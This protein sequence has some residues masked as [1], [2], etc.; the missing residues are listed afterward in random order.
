MMDVETVRGLLEVA[1]MEFML[2][3][4]ILPVILYFLSSLHLPR[5]EC[6]ISRYILESVADSSRRFL[7]SKLSLGS[8]PWVR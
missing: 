3:C 4:D 1:E 7:H 2:L 8:S 6:Q 5:L